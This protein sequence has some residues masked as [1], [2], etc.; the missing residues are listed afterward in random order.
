MTNK[1]HLQLIDIRGETRD[2]R[3]DWKNFVLT[4]VNDHVVRVSVLDRDFHWH[5]HTNSDE[6]FLVIEGELFI[7]LEDRTE[8][9]RAGQ[10]FT[11]PK[12]IR[13]RTR[14]NGRVVN[15]TFEH[16]NADARGNG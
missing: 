12:N 2:I 9:L 10:L 6:T 3:D 7:D 1:N 5:I 15:L 13:H 16:R 11:V 14:A 8:T 4:E